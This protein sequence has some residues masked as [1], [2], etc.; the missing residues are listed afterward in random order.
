MWPVSWLL[1]LAGF[2]GVCCLGAELVVGVGG[3]FHEHEGLCLGEV[4][5]VALAFVFVHVCPDEGVCS[6]EFDGL[7]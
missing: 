5:Y 1:F 3:A 2:E 6:G 7:G 4:G